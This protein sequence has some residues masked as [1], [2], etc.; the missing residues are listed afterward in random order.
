MLHILCGH[1]LGGVGIVNVLF[2]L[3]GLELYVLA[4]VGFLP[5]FRL[6]ELKS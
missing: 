3:G 5:Y 2:R 1:A 4:S 6:A